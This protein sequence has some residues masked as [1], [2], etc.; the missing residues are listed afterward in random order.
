[1]NW[2]AM[3]C[4]RKTRRYFVWQSAADFLSVTELSL[5]DPVFQPAWPAS[6]IDAFTDQHPVVRGACD[7]LPRIG[8]WLLVVTSSTIHF[9]STDWASIQRNRGSVR[10]GVYESFDAHRAVAGIPLA[11]GATD[12]YGELARIVS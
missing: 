12:A 8:V 1:M 11:A 6:A 5:L 2:L 4:S 10:C 3:P 7:A 9:L